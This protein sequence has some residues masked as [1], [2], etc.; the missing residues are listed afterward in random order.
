MQ[1]KDSDI[2]SN[3]L[4]AELRDL[5]LGGERAAMIHAIARCGIPDLLTDGP[6]ASE[7]LA[8][9]SGTVADVLGRVLRA[10]VPSGLFAETSDGKWALAPLGEWLRPNCS[11]SLHPVAI[12]AS[13][14]WIR[15]AWASLE[16]SLRT[17]EVPF[18]N[19]NGTPYFEYLDRNPEARRIFDSVMATRQ[20][21]WLTGLAAAYDWSRFSHVVDVGG[22]HGNLLLSLLHAYPA[23]SGAV[24]DLPEV[25]AV[26]KRYAVWEGLADRIEAVAGNFFSDI[27]PSGDALILSRILNDWPDEACV[28]ILRGC[29]AAMAPSAELLI[30]ERVIEDGSGQRADK[31][32]DVHMHVVLGGK[33]RTRTEFARLLEGAGFVLERVVETTITDRIVVG[34]PV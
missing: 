33:V 5:I 18:D 30:F 10:L 34:R 15:S 4:I 20:A 17:G 16:D 7:V 21:Q 3:F 12:Y 29:R 8:E 28:R 6:L 11:G 9:R 23:L 14:P 31:E 26:V 19:A 24:F 32:A 13:E 27:P 1:A 2:G 25:V 22:G